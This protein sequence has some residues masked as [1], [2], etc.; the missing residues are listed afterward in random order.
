[1]T[2]RNV[3]NADGN[4]ASGPR[5]AR[6][7]VVLAAGGTAGHVEP[8]LN[9]ADAIVR[10]EPSAEVTFVGGDRG[11]EAIL[12]PAR[13]YELLTIPAVPLPRRPSMD[14]VALAPRLA[15]AARRADRLI[16][17]AQADVVVGFGGYAALPT[18]LAA[19]WSGTSLVI[20]EANARAGVANKVGARLTRHV[21]GTY[22]DALPGCLHMGLPLR[23]AIAHLERAQARA[24]GRREF[25]LPES[26][27]VLLV[28]GGSQGATRLNAVVADSLPGL[29]D[30]GVS[31]LHA[32]GRGNP[33]PNVAGNRAEATYVCLP[34]IERM[35]F[36]YAAADFA[37]SR[38]GAMTCAEL[39]TVGL[40]AA[41]VP[42]PIGNGEQRFNALPV[43]EAGGGVLVANEDL[44]ADWVLG[45]VV[46]IL[47]D[48]GRMESMS[49]AASIFGDRTADS[50]FAEVVLG[51]ARQGIEPHESK[52]SGD[53]AE[54]HEE[55]PTHDG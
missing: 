12:V 22:P 54:H 24:A 39:A 49:T 53:S 26:G 44:S 18:Y 13:G 32:Y 50:A 7:R 29:L 25:G 52:R 40:P 36:A 41:Y 5:A 33:Q 17:Q 55:G 4:A 51:I 37:I 28:F 42:L 16:R 31:V 14:L 38:A 11:L 3:A 2:S 45:R 19:R 34:Y 48:R 10:V 20:H 30:S 35:D 46:P 27:P 1:M 23:P 15:R 9:L 43:V 8:A 6:V 21:Y 47:H